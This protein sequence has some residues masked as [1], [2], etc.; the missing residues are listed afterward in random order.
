MLIVETRKLTEEETRH[1]ESEAA[2]VKTSCGTVL[3][4]LGAA[5]ILFPTMLGGLIGSVL[6]AVG[7]GKSLAFGTGLVVGFGVGVRWLFQSLREERNESSALQRALKEDL[8]QGQ[9]EIVS[10]NL[11]QQVWGVSGLE[12]FGPGYVVQAEEDKYIYAAGQEFLDFGDDDIDER[13]FPGSSITLER[14]PHSAIILSLKIDGPPK[15]VEPIEIQWEHLGV[16]IMSGSLMI[17][18]GQF[19]SAVEKSRQDHP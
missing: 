9:A 13:V 6:N 8:V 3:L 4:R 5:F 2:P 17:E 18:P 19:E 16:E 14:V 15:A 12:D 10:V 11:I 1:L 7:L